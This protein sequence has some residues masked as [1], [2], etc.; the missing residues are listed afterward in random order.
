MF[1]RRLEMATEEIN[2]Y[3]LI[4]SQQINKY[5]KQAVLTEEQNSLFDSFYSEC[6]IDKKKLEMLENIKLKTEK[7]PIEMFLINIEK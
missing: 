7:S 2:I 6:L 3:N 4:R 1:N 5:F